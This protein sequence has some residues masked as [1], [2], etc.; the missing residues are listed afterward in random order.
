MGISLTSTLKAYERVRPNLRLK[1]SARGRRVCRNA[2]WKA[3]FLVCGAGGPQLK[4]NPLGSMAHLK[5][6]ARQARFWRPHSSFQPGATTVSFGVA[7]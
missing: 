5:C 7:Q 6:G 1:L 4:R 3:I 2:Q